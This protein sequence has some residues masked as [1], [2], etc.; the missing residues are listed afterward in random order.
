ML[1]INANL[2]E[3]VDVAPKSTSQVELAGDNALLFNC[4]YWVAA[5]VQLARVRRQNESVVSVSGMVSVTSFPVKLVRVVVKAVEP[6][7]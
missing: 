1:F 6:L 3:A 4:Q 7:N 2:A 5:E